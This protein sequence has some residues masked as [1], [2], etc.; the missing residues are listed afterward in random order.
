MIKKE[1]TKTLLNTF[2]DIISSKTF[3][4]LLLNSNVSIK[5]S[6]FSTINSPLV[7]KDFFSSYGKLNRSFASIIPLFC[8][9]GKFISYAFRIAKTSLSNFVFVSMFVDMGWFVF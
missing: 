3:A 5:M 4:F 6:L 7:F 9:I 8:K 1:K 2:K